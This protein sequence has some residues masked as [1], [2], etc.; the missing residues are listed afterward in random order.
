MGH[1]NR[2]FSCVHTIHAGPPPI[3]VL[4]AREVGGKKF[5]SHILPSQFVN[6][7]ARGS[8]AIRG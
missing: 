4:R 8:E 5:I 2:R 6:C 1:E 7:A 3:D